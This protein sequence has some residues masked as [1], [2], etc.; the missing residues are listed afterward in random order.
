[1]KQIIA[2]HISS[3]KRKYVF[4]L[5]MFV[6]GI[7]IGI[8]VVRFLDEDTQSSL[9]SDLN[10]F[11]SNS[12]ENEDNFNRTQYFKKNL[13]GDFQTY[14]LLWLSGLT[15][16]GL[17]CAPVYV[18]FK[19][20]VIGFTNSFIISNYG[21]SGVFYGILTII[22]Q[23][24]IKIPAL[25]FGCASI[26]SYATKQTT[27]RNKKMSEQSGSS[28]NLFLLYSFAMLIAFFISVIGCIIES[29]I[30]P[31]FIFIFTPEML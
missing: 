31:S 16:L 10:R 21:L 30:I 5:A 25:L 3:N 12:I 23:N 4:L 14:L 13:G 17:G 27:P 15:V 20:F 22:P 6:I 26:I 1:M 7:I 28:L 29:Y 11:F 19:G 8:L 24:I 2:E 9:I 18:I